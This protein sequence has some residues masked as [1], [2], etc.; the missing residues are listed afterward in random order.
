MTTKHQNKL[1]EPSCSQG[2]E[3]AFQLIFQQYRHKVYRM[4]FAS[5]KTSAGAEEIL[6][7]VFL[8][9]WVQKRPMET[10]HSL[11]AW[12]HTVTRNSIR[13]S[14]RKN[15]FEAAYKSS[16]LNRNQPTENTADHKIIDAQHEQLIRAAIAMLSKQQ[17]AVYLLAKEKGL[18]YKQIAKRLSLSP[19]TVKK[20]MAR[21]LGTLRQF[22]R[23]HGE[24]IMPA[25][26]LAEAFG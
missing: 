9:L 13:N 16:L 17:Q 8:K 26:L 21:A 20:H 25:L 2:N 23:Q 6:Q 15:N 22:L 7:D 1:W 24:T 3:H 14:L 19:L 5:L 12:L 4:A 10:I 11:E 18:S